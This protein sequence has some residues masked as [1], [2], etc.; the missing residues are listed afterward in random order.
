MQHPTQQWSKSSQHKDVILISVKLT[1]KQKLCFTKALDISTFPLSLNCNL[2][3][4]SLMFSGN[5]VMSARLW[6]TCSVKNLA[7]D[8]SQEQKFALGFF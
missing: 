4:T 8:S 7:Q 6:V 1:G 5:R 2:N 3:K